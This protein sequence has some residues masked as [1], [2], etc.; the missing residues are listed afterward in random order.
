MSDKSPSPREMEILKALWELGPASVR[1][2]RER[3]CPNGELAFNTV[4]TL[5]GSWMRRGWSNTACADGRLFT[6]RSTAA[7]VR[8]RDS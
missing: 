6:R 1:E 2:V 4:Q 8:Q 3:M 5:L 7:I